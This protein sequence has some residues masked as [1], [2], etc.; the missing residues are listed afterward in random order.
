MS[1]HKKI[2]LN[3]YMIKMSHIKFWRGG[4]VARQ[5]SREVEFLVGFEEASYTI[6]SL[7]VSVDSLLAGL[8]GK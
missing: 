2:G 7:V 4:P 5:S 3:R 6:L 8:R 1:P